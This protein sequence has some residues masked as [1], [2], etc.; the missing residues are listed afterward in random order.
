MGAGLP[1]VRILCVY[2]TL[3]SGPLGMVACP[4]LTTTPTLK[5]TCMVSC[6]VLPA[7]TCKLTSLINAAFIGPKFR[8]FLYAATISVV[9]L[10]LSTFR[11]SC[12]LWNASAKGEPDF[13]NF[14]RFASKNWLL[15]NIP[16]VIAH[17]IPD[18][19]S[20]AIG[21]PS[22]KTWWKSW[23]TSVAVGRIYAM[24]T[25]RPNNY[26]N[27]LM[28]LVWRQEEHPVHKNLEWWGAGVVVF[29]SEVKVIQ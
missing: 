22:L 27:A 6:A 3:R 7:G 11:S 15:G 28:L 14:G 26:S 20:T 4:Q 8:K 16:W 25:M 18:W 21:L 19:S 10:R 24:H 5:L 2:L 29:W 1:I 23:N 12:P 17:R 13:A 9:S